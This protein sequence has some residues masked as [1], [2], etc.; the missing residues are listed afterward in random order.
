MTCFQ[1]IREA[2]VR[3]GN[4]LDAA[5]D[6]PLP[7]GFGACERLRPERGAVA[8]RQRA[9]VCVRASKR[10]KSF[11][12]GAENAGKS[13]CAG[14]CWRVPSERVARNRLLSLDIARFLH[15]LG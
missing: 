9:R 5:L 4:N 10:R 6:E 13:P 3:L 15:E 1:L 12:L 7:F 8:R 2:A 11:E 14:P